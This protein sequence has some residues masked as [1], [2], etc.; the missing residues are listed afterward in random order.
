MAGAGQR[1]RILEDQSSYQESMSMFLLGC[2]PP[3]GRMDADSLGIG[4]GGMWV[5]WN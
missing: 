5:L 4:P 3:E 1:G 2:G